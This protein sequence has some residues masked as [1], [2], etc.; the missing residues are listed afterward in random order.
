MKLVNQS[1]CVRLVQPAE[2]LNG[3]NAKVY[4]YT[5][6]IF[7]GIMLSGMGIGALVDAYFHGNC[8]KWNQR[9]WAAY[10]TGAIA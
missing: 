8:N 6:D 4:A 3:R 9:S 1:V 10:H 2:S 7:D 5:G